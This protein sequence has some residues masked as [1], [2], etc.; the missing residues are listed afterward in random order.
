M[1]YLL[2]LWTT[3]SNYEIYP[4]TDVLRPS[5]ARHRHKPITLVQ[6]ALPPIT[7]K[8]TLPHF[9]YNTDTWW[10]NI[11]TE[12]TPSA[13]YLYHYIMIYVSYIMIPY[14]YTS[15]WTCWWEIS[16]NRVALF[17][18]VTCASFLWRLLYVWTS[19]FCTIKLCSIFFLLVNETK[20]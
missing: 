15:F 17:I 2:W 7:W 1:N 10:I 16:G 9:Q 20:W 6:F 4:Y 8:Q 14:H 5:P 19:E 12:L 18:D 11:T 13:K 3:L